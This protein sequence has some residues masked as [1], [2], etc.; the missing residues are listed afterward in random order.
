MD[1][2]G[3]K[4]T[5]GR[6]EKVFGIINSATA[7]NRTFSYTIG[8]DPVTLSAIPTEFVP[9]VPVTLKNLFDTKVPSNSFF[10]PASA[11]TWEPTEST[12][13]ITVK[14]QKGETFTY[15]QYI[16]EADFLGKKLEFRSDLIFRPTLPKADF[17]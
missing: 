15:E 9:E 14:V 5:G 4:L 10:K 7:H 13:S 2:Y 12:K 1:I 6:W 11:V 17:V 16:F 3:A 8:A